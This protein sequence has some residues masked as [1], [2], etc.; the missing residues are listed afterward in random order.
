MEPRHVPVMLQRCLDLLAPALAEPGA[1]VVD[2]TLG[3]GGHSEAL[4]TAFPDVRLVA[5][6]RDPAAL[7]LAGERL[8]P[9]GDRAALVHAVYDELPDVLHRLQIPKVQGVLFDLGVSSMQLDEAERGFA[10]AQDAPLDMRMNQDVGISAAEV[11]NTYPP[12]ELVRILRTYGEEKFARKIVEAI[13]REREREPFS[14]S[15]R[16]VELIRAALPQAAKRTGGNP[17]KRTFQA[18]RIEVNGELAVLERAIPAAVASLAVGGRIAVLSYHSLEDRLVK[19]VFAAGAS[20]TAPP[21]LP[22]IPER[23]QP[24][25]KLLTRGAELPTEEEIAANRRAA[26]ARLRAA[27]RVREDAPDER[28]AP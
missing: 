25:L 1:V 5:V 14:N 26:P 15:A 3:L 11:L 16:L 17:A 27:Q 13:V 8:A 4:L 6:D 21:G 24:R 23:Y 28:A 22:V 9:F 20:N 19:Q 10:Y 2:A 12:G 18:L 7:K